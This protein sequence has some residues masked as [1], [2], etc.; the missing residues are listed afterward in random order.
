GL[1]KGHEKILSEEGEEFSVI[2]F[3]AHAD[4][5]DF[6]NNSTLNHACVAKQVSK[7]HSQ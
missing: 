3:D 6:W 5:R 7:K 2:Q 4:F 1:V